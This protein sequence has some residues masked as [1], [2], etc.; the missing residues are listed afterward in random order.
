MNK[1]KF[2]TNFIKGSL[3]V[4]ISV[5]VVYGVVQAGSIVVPSGTP[6]ASFYTLSDIW[7]RLTTNAGAGVHSFDFTD[8][9]AGTHVTLTQ[10]YN[11]IPTIDATQVKLSTPYLGITGTLVPS[12]GDVVV[13]DVLSGK[14]FFGASQSDWVLK[15][16]TMPNKVGSTTIF[17]PSTADQAIT[18]GYYGGVVGDGKVLGDEDLVSGNI[19]SGVN[20]FGVDGDTN[21][22]NTSTGDAVAGNILLDKIA[23][24]DG[25]S[26]TGTMPN[27]GAFS[28]T[29]GVSDQAVTAGYYSGG[30]L[31]GDPDLLAKSIGADINIF[32]VT[33][34]L[35][36]NLYN[37]TCSSANP[38]CPLG[39]EFN[40]GSQADGGIDDYNNNKAVPVGRYSKNWTTCTAAG[41][42]PCGI[43]NSGS[44]F[45]D[46]STG[47]IW[48]KKMKT[49]TYALDDTN[50]QITWFLAN[51][52]VEQTGSAC[53]K[54][55]LPGT[56]TGCE[57]NAGWYLPTQKQLM[58]AYIDGSYGNMEPALGSYRLYWSSTTYSS[59]VPNAWY[60]GLSNG[61]TY[62]NTKT[63]TFSVRCV[64]SAP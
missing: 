2:F 34:T 17:T 18:Q 39:T 54:I 42:D 56:L 13:G 7:T 62:A 37:G 23:Y 61:Y 31:A 21:V 9:L 3:T 14:T 44:A 49:V 1:N 15:T 38:L 53:T 41:D 52:C 63:T 45:R 58:Q 50:G 16:G 25:L 55:T 4:L 6:S 22:V 35:L 40:G 64:R 36:K 8:T 32:G 12:G 47:L 29:A 19:K 28:L 10:I 30:T 57:A 5:L 24:V 20:I 48:S 60:T 51:N 33:G 27:N 11:A 26:V 59:N 43:S 46:D